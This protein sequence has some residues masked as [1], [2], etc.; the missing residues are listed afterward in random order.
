MAEVMS[1]SVAILVVSDR[2]YASESYDRCIPVFREM[3]LP[4]DFDIQ[5]TIITS[6]DPTMIKQSLESLI[7]KRYALVITSGGT[8]CGPRDNTPEVT[9][10]LL[11]KPTPGVD[12]A[13]RRF[14]AT[15]SDFAIYS[16]AVSGIA[17]RSFVLSLPGSPNAVREILEFLLPSLTHPLKLIAGEV[18]DCNSE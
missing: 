16:R 5:E 14:S 4:P 1:H 9:K 8:G 11:D 10:A 13:I 18:S 17:G 15:K 3:L 2:A 12:E 6:D 7:A